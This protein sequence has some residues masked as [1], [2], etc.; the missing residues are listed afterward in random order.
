MCELPMTK[1]AVVVLGHGSRRQE[2]NAE[3]EEIINLLAQRHDGWLIQKAY[4][5]FAE[6]TLEQAVESLLEQG[7][8][9]IVLMPFFLTMGN[10]LNKNLPD[11][12]AKLTAVNPHL[13]ITEARHLGADLLM[14]QLIEK[15]I[16]EAEKH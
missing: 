11:R 9:D 16:A 15:R 5:E 6:P 3:L 2:A 7:I 12:L 14:V 10:H 8:T 4:A 1:K 13:S